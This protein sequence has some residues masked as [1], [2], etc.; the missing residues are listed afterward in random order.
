[1]PKKKN[2]IG[3]K[4]QHIQHNFFQKKRNHEKKTKFCKNLL[5]SLTPKIDT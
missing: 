5:P 2:H 3:A 1:M 4:I